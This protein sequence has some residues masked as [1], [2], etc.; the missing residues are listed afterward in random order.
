[1]TGNIRIACGSCDRSDF[2]GVGQI[3]TDWEDVEEVQSLEQSR[4]EIDVDDKSE[5]PFDWYTHI[6]TC[7]SCQES[8]DRA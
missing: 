2:D 3:P 5:S 4:R 7:P 8:C 1:M 6:G